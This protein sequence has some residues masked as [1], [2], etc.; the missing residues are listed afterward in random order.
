MCGHPYPAFYLCGTN[1]LK[2]IYLLEE[3]AAAE[4]SSYYVF[5]AR[6]C[7]ECVSSALVDILE[8]CFCVFHL[9]TSGPCLNGTV[10][11]SF[12]S[13]FD[14]VILTAHIVCSCCCTYVGV[15]DT[16]HRKHYVTRKLVNGEPL[17]GS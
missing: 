8:L 16:V 9:R 5:D 10:F 3:K 7:R 6:Y 14:K 13:G 17:I 2:G 1:I 12:R 15:Y 4:E 11:G